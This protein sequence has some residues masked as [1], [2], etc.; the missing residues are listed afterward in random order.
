[1]LRRLNREGSFKIRFRCSFEESCIG[2]N[3]IQHRE[4]DVVSL[5]Q[6]DRVLESVDSE[7]GRRIQ[8]ETRH[9]HQAHG[10]IRDGEY[11]IS[12]IEMLY[13]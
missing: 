13:I 3:R 2:S 6:T 1:M 5:L 8:R 7:L 11:P 9:P 12:A 10:G 4:L